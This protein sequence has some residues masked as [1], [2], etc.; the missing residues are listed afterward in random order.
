MVSACKAHI[1][2]NDS[3]R[4]WDVEPPDLLK[5]FQACHNLFQHYQDSFQN[6]KERAKNTSRSFEV[7]EMYVFGKFA[8]F[9]RRLTQVQEM[10]E[11]IQQFAV[12]KMSRIE[13]IDAF[14]TRFGHI[15]SS[16]KKK[17]YN[18]LDHRKLEFVTDYEEFQRQVAEL[19]DQL[20]AFMIK[21]FSQ[22]HSTLQSLKL[23]KR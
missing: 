11:L 15:V 19:E 8:S 6:A 23:L 22:V 17:P 16:I 1:T 20:S 5:K 18:A 9:C 12:L 3:L 21:I 7:S 4:V 2:D 14:A 13:G 10:V